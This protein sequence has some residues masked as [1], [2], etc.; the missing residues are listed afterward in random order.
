MCEL[1]LETMCSESITELAGAMLK[2]QGCLNPVRKDKVNGFIGNKYATLSS[3]VESCREALI[4]NGIWLTQYPVQ[5]ESGRP[6]LGLV[7]KLTHAKSGEWQSSLLVMPLV[8]N[9]PQG[10]GSAMTYARRYGLSALVG[11]VTDDDDGNMASNRG[12]CS[13]VHN[14][15]KPPFK[16]QKTTAIAGNKSFKEAN[17]SKHPETYINQNRPQNRPSGLP[18]IDGVVFKDVK[19]DEGLFITASGNTRSKATILK[20]AGFRWDPAQKLWWKAAS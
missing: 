4:S 1:T 15:H 18:K 3:V 19:S 2:V 9:D 12:V 7:T 8:K 14:G 6:E 5:I 11:I 17:V 10:Y 13:T 16:P 20:Q